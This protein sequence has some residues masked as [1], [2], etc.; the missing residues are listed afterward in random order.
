VAPPP[1]TS[2][3]REEANIFDRGLGVT[4]SCP[5]KAGKLVIVKPRDRS[6]ARMYQFCDQGG[7][8]R[9]LCDRF[10]GLIREE[11]NLNGFD[12]T[13]SSITQRAAYILRQQNYSEY[14]PP[15]AVRV[16][17]ESGCVVSCYV[18]DILGKL[19]RHFVSPV[20][21]DLECLSADPDNPW[22]PNL[23]EGKL[24]EQMDG[25]WARNTYKYFTDE[26]C[27]GQKDE[28]I[29]QPLSVYVDKTGTDEI[30]KNSLEPVMV[31][32]SL[33]KGSV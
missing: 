25:R 12:I 18:F 3:F 14:N 27:S 17:L 6:L 30:E 32:S 26:V 7:N 1:P 20:F 2:L 33:L 15:Q 13:S 31:V 8:A 21:G 4:Y 16:S 23:R 24:E 29:I 28:Y 5:E 9:D 11:T 22:Q 10:L 19:G